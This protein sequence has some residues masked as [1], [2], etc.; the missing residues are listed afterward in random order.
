M[1]NLNQVHER[2]IKEKLNKI[3]N[4]IKIEELK[5]KLD[6][7]CAENFGDI[8]RILRPP[9][10]LGLI[11]AKNYGG[12]NATGDVIVFLDAHCEATNGW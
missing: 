4:F 12:Q 8:V 6:D 11:A 9:K 2:I 3:K 7:Y 10:R 5:Q 1:I